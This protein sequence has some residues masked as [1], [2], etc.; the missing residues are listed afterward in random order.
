MQ[1]SNSNHSDYKC[2][3]NGGQLTNITL[4][5]HIIPLNALIIL[6]VNLC[7]YGANRAR[8]DETGYLTVPNNYCKAPWYQ[9]TGH[10]LGI[11]C[12]LIVSLCVHSYV[13][14]N[15]TLPFSKC[16]L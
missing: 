4:S 10:M 14:V 15:S 7:V 3:N 6:R 8:G 16:I 13:S 2:C 12:N 9:F 11:V 5:Q 1:Q